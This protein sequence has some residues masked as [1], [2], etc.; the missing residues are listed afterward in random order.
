MCVRENVSSSWSLLLCESVA[1]AVVVVDDAIKQQFLSL[2]LSFLPSSLTARLCR[3]PSLLAH[4]PRPS[5][6]LES[7]TVLA[8]HCSSRRLCRRRH[9]RLLLVKRRPCTSSN[10]GGSAL[11]RQPRLLAYTHIHM[12]IRTPPLLSLLILIP[13]SSLIFFSSQL[14]LSHFNSFPLRSLLSPQL[15]SF[16]REREQE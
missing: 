7:P 3:W 10:T 5:V 12:H 14:L 16:G 1:V 11:T 4:N 15:L 6:R 2:F 8:V 9:H 13:R